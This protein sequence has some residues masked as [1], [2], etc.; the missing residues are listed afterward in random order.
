MKRSVTGKYLV[1]LVFSFV[2]ITASVGQA[3]TVSEMNYPDIPFLM[4]YSAT[5][6]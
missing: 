5:R 4:K 3:S 6:A 2:A 1:V